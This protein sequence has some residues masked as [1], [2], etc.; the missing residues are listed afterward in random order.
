MPFKSEAQRR[1]FH[2]KAARG[3]ISKATVH[4]W[5]HATKNK[6]SLPKHVEKHAIEA[7]GPFR[8]A[9]PQPTFKE[10]AG[11]V[12]ARLLR[13]APAP[14]QRGVVGYGVDRATAHLSSP[15]GQ[16]QMAQLPQEQLAANQG[17]LA[18]AATFSERPIPLFHQLKAYDQGSQAALSAFNAPRPK[19]TLEQFYKGADAQPPL[20]T[21][22]ATGTAQGLSSL[23]LNL[24]MAPK[25]DKLRQGMIGG[26]SDALGGGIGGPWGMGASMLTNMALQGL[27]APKQHHPQVDPRLIDY[28]APKM[29]DHADDRL[30]ERINAD[31]PPDVLAQLRSQAIKLDVSPGRYYLPMKD[32]SGNT[33]AVA[34]FKTVGKDNKLVLATVLKPK[35]KPPP[36][37]SLSH[38][39]KQPTAPS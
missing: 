22:A 6:K 25:G 24:A 39:M 32:A 10:Q 23:V 29:A 19:K 28:D 17:T 13:A 15:K 4:E 11:R 20:P 21:R 18:R 30:K 38:L 34:A 37:T 31:F 8:G 33:A 26:V 1:L 2:A 35:G 5:E 9:A 12:A 36:G 7:L 27:T 16:A 14:I 3:E